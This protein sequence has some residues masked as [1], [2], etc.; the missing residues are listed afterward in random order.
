MKDA[1]GNE[2]RVEFAP[3]AFDHF[4]GTQEELDALQKEILEHIGNLTPEQLAA[5]SVEV[6]DVYI[7]QLL[8]ED[9]EQAELLIQALTQD[10]TARRLQ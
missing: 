5:S 2:I 8:E 10:P 9:P 4:E 6:D 1:E 3:G 7:E